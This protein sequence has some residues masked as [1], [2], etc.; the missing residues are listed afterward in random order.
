MLPWEETNHKS[1][2][3]DREYIKSMG[4]KEIKRNDKRKTQAHGWDSV[5]TMTRVVPEPNT[6]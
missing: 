3:H 6:P 4:T 5:E 1:K 2:D